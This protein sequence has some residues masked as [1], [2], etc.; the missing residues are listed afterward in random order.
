[1]GSNPIH[2]N[3]NTSMS[4]EY[5]KIYG[6]I[7]EYSEFNIFFS[8]KQKCSYFNRSQTNLLSGKVRHIFIKNYNFFIKYLKT[9]RK[10]RIKH[11]KNYIINSKFLEE[12][13]SKILY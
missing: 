6:L 2:F 8:F 7:L 1:M 5:T 13:N 12:S 3:T 9:A 10:N 4:I 11:L